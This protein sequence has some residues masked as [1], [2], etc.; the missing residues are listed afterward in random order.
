MVKKTLSAK[1]LH[2]YFRQDNIC[3]NMALGRVSVAVALDD[4]RRYKRGEVGSTQPLCLNR[5]FAVETLSGKS[6]RGIFCLWLSDL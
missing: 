5:E 2:I 3:K 4:D 1:L 6:R